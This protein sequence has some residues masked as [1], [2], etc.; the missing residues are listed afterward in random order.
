MD[1]GG[2]VCLISGENNVFKNLINKREHCG[3]GNVVLMGEFDTV[4]DEVTDKTARGTSQSVL[5]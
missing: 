2:D 4:I 1:S 5:L 3:K